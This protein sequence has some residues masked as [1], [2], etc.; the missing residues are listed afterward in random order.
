[1]ELGSYFP[2]LCFQATEDTGPAS[3]QSSWRMKN[4]G[5]MAL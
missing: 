4:V 1:M 3:S 2:R 5:A